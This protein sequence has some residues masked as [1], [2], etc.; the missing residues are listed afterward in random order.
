MDETTARLLASEIESKMDSLFRWSPVTDYQ[1]LQ[2]WIA[3]PCFD[4]DGQAPC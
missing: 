1:A 2:E 3:L 4:P